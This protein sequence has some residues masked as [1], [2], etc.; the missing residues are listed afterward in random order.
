MG[1]QMLPVNLTYEKSY[2]NPT[3]LNW[4]VSVKRQFSDKNKEDETIILL[5]QLCQN[6]QSACYDTTTF[7]DT[8]SGTVARNLCSGETL[9]IQAAPE[10]ACWHSDP[11][12]QIFG[13][14]L[15]SKSNSCN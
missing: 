7:M 12:Q 9:Y 15:I 10:K 6:N 13:L 11:K 5:N 2:S 14:V 1:I 8:M 3:T 4:M